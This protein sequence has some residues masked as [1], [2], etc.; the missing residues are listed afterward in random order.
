MITTLLLLGFFAAALAWV[1]VRAGAAGKAAAENE[2]KD[3]I[4]KNAG[5]ANDVRRR[6]SDNPADRLRDKWSRD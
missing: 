1:V 6:R 4:L 3:E 2:E 5:I